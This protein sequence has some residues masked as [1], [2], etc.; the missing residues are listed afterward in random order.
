MTKF[1][2]G[3]T[4]SCRSICDSNCKWDFT[5]LNRTNITVKIAVSGKVVS[6]KIYLDDIH[7]E[8]IKPLGS[9]SMAPILRS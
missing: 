6:K 1:E 7:G 8:Y 3:K 4:Y 5:I 2:T 9:Y